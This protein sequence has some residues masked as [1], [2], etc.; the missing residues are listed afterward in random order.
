MK[1]VGIGCRPKG[2]NCDLRHSV[3]LSRASEAEAGEAQWHL[4]RCK[5]LL[6][7]LHN[8]GRLPGM[9]S[10][11]CWLRR[12]CNAAFSSFLVSSVARVSVTE[13]S[14][15]TVENAK[16]RRK[17]QECQNLEAKR[18][19]DR[20]KERKA[21]WGGGQFEVSSM[22]WLPRGYQIQKTND[23]RK[24]TWSSTIADFLL[25]LFASRVFCSSW[26]LFC[27]PPSAFCL[28]SASPA[29]S[30]HIIWKWTENLPHSLFHATSLS[31][32]RI[33]KTQNKTRPE[34]LRTE[35]AKLR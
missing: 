35:K 11:S 14:I 2:A 9:M 18:C 24:E 22:K 16:E 32:T 12:L 21:G 20:I 5:T 7:K 8:K 17:V 15:M 6:R 19:Y 34:Q 27:L 30:S 33:N 29:R 4:F 1:W 26:T 28:L 23:V 13:S 10:H 3:C 31:K 25:H